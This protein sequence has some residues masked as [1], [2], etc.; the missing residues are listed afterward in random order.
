[1]YQHSKYLQIRLLF[2]LYNI[3]MHPT[4]IMQILTGAENALKF[5]F[6]SCIRVCRVE[7]E[8]IYLKPTAR[9]Y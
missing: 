5:N 4:K 7:W 8:V 3:L 6:Q 9:I 2:I 1:M